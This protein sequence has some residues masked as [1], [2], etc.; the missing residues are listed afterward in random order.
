M[1]R[2]ILAGFS[3]HSHSIYNIIPL[4]ENKKVYP[5]TAIVDKILLV[6]QTGTTMKRGPYETLLMSSTLLLQQCLAC[7]DH[8]TLMVLEMGDKWPYTCCFSHKLKENNQV[9]KY[10]YIIKVNRWIKLK[11]K[12]KKEKCFLNIYH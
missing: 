7:L 4:F 10:T 2:A 6:S 12:S 5:V 11:P 9:K 3:D 1:S 8:F